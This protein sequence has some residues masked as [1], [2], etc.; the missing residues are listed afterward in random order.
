MGYFIWDRDTRRVGF[1]DKSESLYSDLSSAL[2][3][4]RKC[5]DLRRPR[6]RSKFSRCFDRLAINGRA[7]FYANKCEGF[8]CVVQQQIIR[9]V[10]KERWRANY[11]AA[12]RTRNHDR[13]TGIAS[14][15]I[16]RRSQRRPAGDTRYSSARAPRRCSCT[17]PCTPA[18]R[19]R[20]S[21]TPW[22]WPRT[23]RPGASA[24]AASIIV[25]YRRYWLNPNLRHRYFLTRVLQR[26]ARDCGL[27]RLGGNKKQGLQRYW[28]REKQTI[29]LEIFTFPYRGRILLLLVAVGEAYSQE[30]ALAL[31]GPRQREVSLHLTGLQTEGVLRSR[32]VAYTRL[33][34]FDPDFCAHREPS[35]FLHRW[36][37]Y[38]QDIVAAANGVFLRR[39]HILATGNAS[40]RRMIAAIK[41]VQRSVTGVRRVRALKIRRKF[42]HFV[43]VRSRKSDRHNGS[44]IYDSNHRSFVT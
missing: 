12:S 34:S 1:G 19:P 5:Y 31:A 23:G 18:A 42:T 20:N 36:A 16:A 35:S 4:I 29:P 38:R 21:G 32:M 2:P 14:P 37:A 6:C 43:P 39:E 11:S 13:R 8:R 44:R 3:F 41:P 27:S 17:S 9:A 22:I 15:L 10:C 40:M 28:S 33:Y 30:I 24:C 7:S 26:L 25:G